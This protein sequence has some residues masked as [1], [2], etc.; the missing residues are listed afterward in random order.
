MLLGA[1]RCDKAGVIAS[2]WKLRDVERELCDGKREI[3]RLEELRGEEIVRRERRVTQR[4]EKETSRLAE[5][6]VASRTPQNLVQD[7]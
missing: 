4:V 6:R 5:L 7:A 3:S 1:R 2:R